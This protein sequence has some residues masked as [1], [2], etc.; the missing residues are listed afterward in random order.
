[1]GK[2]EDEKTE[3][4]IYV[5]VKMGRCEDENII[6]TPAIIRTLRSDVA[7]K[8]KDKNREPRGSISSA[9]VW[10]PEEVMGK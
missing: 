4:M 7:K 9:I 6:Q 1:M 2:C 3:K 5:D 10:K 8:H